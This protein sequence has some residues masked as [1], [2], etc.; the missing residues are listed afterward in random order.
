M[1]VR[2]KGDLSG[3]RNGARWPRRGETIDLPPAE[4]AELCAT[5]M[6]EPV[7]E[8]RVERAVTSTPEKRQARKRT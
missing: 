7:E 5:G 8:S 4:A 3:T 2:I 6:A 1:L